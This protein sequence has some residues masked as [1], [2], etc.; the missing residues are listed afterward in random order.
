MKKARFVLVSTKNMVF[1]V[2]M[3]KFVITLFLTVGLVWVLNKSFNIGGVP[4]PAFGSFLSPFTG[5]WQNAALPLPATF[6]NIS[7]QGVQ[8]KTEIAY[9][10]RSVPH[11]FAD[12][13]M[14]VFFV[15]GYLHA[16]DRLWQ[17]DFSTR[18]ASGRLSEVLGEKSLV[19]GTNYLEWDK[20]QR[21]KGMVFAAENAVKGW[22]KFPETMRLLES[23]TAGANAY[24]NGLKPKDYPVEFKIMG[25]KPEAWTI[26]K[27]A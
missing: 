1:M 23:Y 6:P 3:V 19:N 27:T 9:D 14:D 18:A 15:Q 26:L 10:D 11:V 5:F 4:A 7:V 24:I 2:K 16:K 17:M 12:S 20:T 22:A 25:Y 13:L 21:R 8:G